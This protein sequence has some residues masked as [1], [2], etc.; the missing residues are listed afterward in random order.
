MAG[1]LFQKNNNKQK[2]KVKLEL[3][4]YRNKLCTLNT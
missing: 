3:P 1:V 4:K 2:K